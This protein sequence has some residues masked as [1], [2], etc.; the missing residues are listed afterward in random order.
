[1]WQEFKAFLIKQ[2][3]LALAIAVVVGA[4]LNDVVKSLV[5]GAIM[6]L[7]AAVSPDPSSYQAMEWVIGPFHFK[8]GLIIVALVNFLIIGLVAWRLTKVFVREVPTPP[9][10]S[11]KTCPFCLMEDVDARASRCP[12]CTSQIDQGAVGAPAAGYARG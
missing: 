1:M 7:V 6:P 10:R 5:D 12:H 11:L 2:N 9:A 3:V 4:A 8:P